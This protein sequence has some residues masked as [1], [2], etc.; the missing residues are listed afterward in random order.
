MAIV[1]WGSN[2]FVHRLEPGRPYGFWIGPADRFLNASIVVTAQPYE[3]IFETTS[4]SVQETTLQWKSNGHRI[5]WFTLINTGAV[6]IRSF[7]VFLGTI[8]P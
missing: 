5:V 3:P 7:Y 2:Y 4:I 6:P 8:N 1:T